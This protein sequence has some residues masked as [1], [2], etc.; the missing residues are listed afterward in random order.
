MVSNAPIPSADAVPFDSAE[1]RL[2]RLESETADLRAE[3][4]MLRRTKVG[5]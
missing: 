2:L 5:D 3:N 4:A 1:Q